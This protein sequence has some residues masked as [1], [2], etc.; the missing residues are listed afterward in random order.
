MHNRPGIFTGSGFPM[1]FADTDGSLIDVYQ[2]ATQA[3]DDAIRTSRAS[4][5]TT[6]PTP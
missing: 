5:P 3:T 1:R 6:D 2:A 4:R